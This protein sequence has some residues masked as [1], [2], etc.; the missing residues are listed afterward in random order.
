MPYEIIAFLVG[1]SIIVFLKFGKGSLSGLSFPKL[2]LISEI[3]AWWGKKDPEKKT[4]FLYAITAAI[5]ITIV[6]LTPEKYSGSRYEIAGWFVLLVLHLVIWPFF[7]NKTSLGT[8]III[9]AILIFYPLAVLFPNATKIWVADIKKSATKF[10]EGYG[11]EPPPAPKATATPAVYSQQALASQPMRI[12]IGRE[13]SAEIRVPGGRNF[14]SWCDQPGAGMVIIY[15]RGISPY[16]SG[17]PFKCP[18]K[19][20]TVDYGHGFMNLRLS[21]QSR[22][23]GNVAIIDF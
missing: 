2:S 4:W 21:F 23:P 19:T 3:K 10:D 5:A 16:P 20:D 13:W 6:Y 15:D 8:K 17:V 22:V 7:T 1:L 14:K 11:K 9:S 12:A 18:Q